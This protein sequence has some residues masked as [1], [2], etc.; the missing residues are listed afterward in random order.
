[1]ARRSGLGKRLDQILEDSQ[2]GTYPAYEGLFRKSTGW[3][4]GPA[5]PFPLPEFDTELD[6][7]TPFGPA[8]QEE[9]DGY[10]TS[11][12]LSAADVLLT[13]GI[14]VSL[15]RPFTVQKATDY[16]QG[17]T[18]STRISAYYY[19]MPGGSSETAREIVNVYEELLE[20]DRFSISA[21]LFK[22]TL[23]CNLYVKWQRGKSRAPGSYVNT[24]SYEGVLFKD[25]ENFTNSS[26]LGK[27]V[28]SFIYKDY[29]SSDPAAS[30]F[31]D[32]SDFISEA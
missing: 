20:R 2:A 32:Y 14:P 4:E 12:R 29:D 19:S 6:D 7:D 5:T 13:L 25:F 11:R 21:S 23:E 26:S 18:S 30:M 28:L 8:E 24:S 3:D 1:M 31:F 16:D 10:T 9:S 22:N 17:P 27:D 15:F